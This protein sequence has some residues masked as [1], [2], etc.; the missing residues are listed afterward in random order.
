MVITYDIKNPEAILQYARHLLN[1]TLREFVDETIIG[2][3]EHNRLR[4]W[5]YWN[6]IEKYYFWYEPNSRPEPD[7]P[8]AWLEVKTTP[9][10][11]LKRWWKVPKERL[12][13]NMISFMDI[14]KEDWSNSSF[15]KKNAKLLLIIYL[16]EKEKLPRDYIVELV[17]IWTFPEKDLLMIQKDWQTIQNKVRAGKAHEL[18]EWDTLY[19][20]ACTKSATSANRTAQPFSSEM[21]K[22]RAFSLKAWYI[23]TIIER[24]IKKEQEE[25][26]LKDY[27][28]LTKESFEEYVK[29]KFTDYCE[30]TP[31]QIADKLWIPLD[32]SKQYLATLARQILWVQWKKIEE[33]E[34][35]NITMK[36]MRLNTKGKVKE[37][38]SFP[39][40]DPKEI[41]N[42]TREDSEV[43]EM[44]DK[45]FFFVIFQYNNR[46]ELY[47]KKVIFW[48]IPY[49]DLDLDVRRVFEETKRRISKWD[50]KNLPKI[51]END[52][53]HVRP[54]A[55]NKNDTVEYPNGEKDIKKCF[56]LNS[57]YITKQIQ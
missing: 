26:I 36:V 17:N 6:M 10:K 25:A 22:P 34:K 53:A 56:W 4:R 45:K 20:W 13:M 48:N 39:F 1:K 46:W 16:Y 31:Q 15:L 50:I 49:R 30:K 7:F 52:V 21:A 35:A 41:V 44:M 51:K 37:S 43:L 54:H 24:F 55:K 47:L 40:F 18:S 11:K 32:T 33:F 3:F 29:N 19:L 28:I 42:E 23:K 5:E 14:V 2:E 27:S 9:L 12:V 8:I 57:K 38:I